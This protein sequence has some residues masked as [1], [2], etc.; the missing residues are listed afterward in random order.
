MVQNVSYQLWET[1]AGI[2]SQATLYGRSIL[3]YCNQIFHFV[4]LKILED[5][6]WSS[7]TAFESGYFS[8]WFLCEYANQER[9]R[10]DIGKKNSSQ[11]ER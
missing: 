7:R 10:L 11:E 6:I 9:F 8:L 2:E 1:E 4:L 3:T 5:H